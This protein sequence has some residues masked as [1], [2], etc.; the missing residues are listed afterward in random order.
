MGLHR[1]E[2]P[3]DV[4]GCFGC[5][6]MGL[7]LSSGDANSGRQVSEKKW[8]A[9]NNAF[10][11]AVNQGINPGGVFQKDI[12]AAH[13]ASEILGRPYD[14]ETM[15][16]AHKITKGVAEIYKEIGTQ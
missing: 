7:E 12:D 3:V 13:K 6:I 11:S 4:D 1:R 16:P 15:L 2:H 10:A 5:K 8:D 9:E 14:A